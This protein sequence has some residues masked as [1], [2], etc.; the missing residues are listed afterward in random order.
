M[1]RMSSSHVSKDTWNSDGG[2]AI[3]RRWSIYGGEATVSVRASAGTPMTRTRERGKADR[4][5][6]KNF[7]AF[8]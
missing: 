6:S 3:A 1:R 5:R 2:R 7:V 4:D 8:I